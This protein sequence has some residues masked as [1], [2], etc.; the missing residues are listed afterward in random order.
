MRLSRFV[1]ATD[2][3]RGSRRESSSGGNAASNLF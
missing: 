2:R 3:M 1:N